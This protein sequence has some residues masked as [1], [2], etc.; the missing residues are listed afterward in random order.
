MRPLAVLTFAFALALAGCG[1]SDE[2]GAQEDAGVEPQSDAAVQ[3]D[4]SPPAPRVVLTT[5]LGTIEIQLFPDESP[6]GTENFLGY[7][8]AQFYDGTIFHRVIPDFMI[9][10]GGLTDNMAQKQTEAPI[11]NEAGNGLSNT[12]GTVAWARTSNID[13]ATSQFF[14]NVVDNTFLDHKD[15]TP[16]GFGYAVFGEVVAGMDVVDQIVAVP[17]QTVGQYQDVPVTAVVITSAVRKAE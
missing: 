9:Q 8:D 6:I 13:S 10:G 11:V 14:I 7:V 1:G 17:T 12:R 4:G 16:T 2:P 5:T 3:E 15:D